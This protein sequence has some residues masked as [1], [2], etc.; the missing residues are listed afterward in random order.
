MS[1]SILFS[2]SV[3]ATGVVSCDGT[4]CPSDC[5]ACNKENLT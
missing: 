4:A 3:H 5:P 1:D 2:L